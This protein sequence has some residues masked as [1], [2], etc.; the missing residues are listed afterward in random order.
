MQEMIH[1]P[2]DHEL[3]VGIAEDATFGPILVVGHG[4]TAVEVIGDKAIGL[5]PLNLVLAHEMISRTCVARLLGGYRDRP[6]ADVDAVASTLAETF[7]IADRLPGDR[8]ARYQSI[9]GGSKRCVGS[10]WGRISVRPADGPHPRMAIRP[11]PAEFEH[12][13]EIDGGRRLQVRP[14]RPEDEPEP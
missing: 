4:G 3:L 5:P 9:A 13:V 14:I 11:Y 6:P 12:E 8:R 7:R 2:Q 1:R 10:R